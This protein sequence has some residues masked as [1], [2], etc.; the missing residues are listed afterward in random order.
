MATDTSTKCA[1]PECGCAPDDSSKYCSD[2]CKEAAD[3][4]EIACQCGHPGCPNR[5]N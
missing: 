3:L 4:T 1:H 5:A 2:S